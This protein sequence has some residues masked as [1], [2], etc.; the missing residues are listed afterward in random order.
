MFVGDDEIAIVLVL[1]RQPIFDTPHPMPEM[2]FSRRRITRKNSRLCRHAFILLSSPLWRK[3]DLK[4]TRKRE[5]A[6]KYREWTSPRMVGAP[7]SS[8][9]AGLERFGALVAYRRVTSLA[10]VKHL[11]VFKDRSSSFFPAAVMLM[12]NQLG[13]KGFEEALHHRIVITVSLS[14]HARLD[15]LLT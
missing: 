1:Q 15:A 12:I 8:V 14:A 3:Q 5:G 13:L 9:E 10:I 6:K 2:Q 4:R 11:D 7:N